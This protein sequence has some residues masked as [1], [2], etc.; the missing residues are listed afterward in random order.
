MRVAVLKGNGI[1]PEITQATLRVLEATGI[2]FEWEDVLVADEAIEK[3]G[4]PLPPESLQQLRSAE[5]AIKAPLI[6][7]RFKGRVDCPR[8]DG[9]VATYPS[10]N[11]AIRRE[12]GV[13]VNPRPVKGFPGV[14]GR[15][16]SLD[17]VIMREITEDL[18]AGL[19]HIIGDD[20]AAQAIKLTTRTAVTKVA[21]FSFE[22][23]RKHG[24]KRVTCLHKANALSLT[25]GL[26]LR[27]FNEVSREYGDIVADDMM[28]DA[29]CYTIVRD[30]TRFDVVVTANQYGDIFSDLAAGL[31]G[32]LGL[33]PGANIGDNITMVEAC[34]GAAPD[35]A[36][37]GVAN[38]L[39]LILSS[40]I[41][42]DSVGYPKEASAIRESARSVVGAAKDII[43]PDLRGSGTTESLT[44]A[45]VNGLSGDYLENK[46]YSEKKILCK[47]QS[48]SRIMCFR[49]LT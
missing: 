10:I 37:K 17:V 21:R 23:A 38:P 13:F 1:G 36:G 8:E 45:M 14:S 12:L 46:P 32:S 5:I 41:L 28:I 47:L 48:L 9:S 19:E 43:T 44:T 20:L 24:R 40:A 26:F 2:P 22:Y 3:Y 39:S 25:D 6:V 42:L 15:H 49:P 11:N 34:H 18:Y 33:A 29:A 27:C 7:E 35:I 16:E 31:A 4:H 30:P